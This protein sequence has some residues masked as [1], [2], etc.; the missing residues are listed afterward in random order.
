MSKEINLT[1]LDL[2]ILK[3]YKEGNEFC[4][5]ESGALWENLRK[6]DYLDSDLELTRK[7]AEFIKNYPNWDKIES[8]NNK[9]YI[10]IK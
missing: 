6:I 4:G 2:S 1:E 10:S 3:Y 5:F 8:Y 7:G 9:M